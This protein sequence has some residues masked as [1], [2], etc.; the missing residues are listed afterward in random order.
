M[1]LYSLHTSHVE[2]DRRPLRSHGVAAL[3][4]SSRSHHRS[5]RARLRGIDGSGTE[6]V[7]TALEHEERWGK[8]RLPVLESRLFHTV[9]KRESDC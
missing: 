1:L 2:L 3:S 8:P 9:Q 5:A 6:T 4:S 7:H